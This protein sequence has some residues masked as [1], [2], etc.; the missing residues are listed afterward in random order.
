MRNYRGAETEQHLRTPRPWPKFP[1]L[2]VSVL[3]IFITVLA[4]VSLDKL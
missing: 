3:V 2:T 4:L 1:A